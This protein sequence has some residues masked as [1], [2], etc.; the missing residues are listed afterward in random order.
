MTLSQGYDLGESWND[1]RLH[2]I[3]HCDRTLERT[4]LVLYPGHAH[5]LVGGRGIFLPL[6][7]TVHFFARAASLRF[8]TSGKS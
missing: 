7:A 4:G 1:Y 2:L 6:V 3:H 5:L 8:R